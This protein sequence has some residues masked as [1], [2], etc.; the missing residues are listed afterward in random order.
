MKTL[1]FI[2]NIPE[3]TKLVNL[4]TGLVHHASEFTSDITISVEGSSNHLTID[5]KSILGVM[6]LVYASG[7]LV[8]IEINGEDEELA[9]ACID[10]YTS[11]FKQ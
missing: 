8:H 2:L 11:K 10:A 3:E 5:L 7:K 4:C 6:S 1:D 9:F